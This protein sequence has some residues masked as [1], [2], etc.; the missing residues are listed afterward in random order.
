MARSLCRLQ[1]SEVV[2][3]PRDRSLNAEL[4]GVV[5]MIGKRYKQLCADVLMMMAL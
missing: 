2:A 1:G 5:G 3:P 4:T